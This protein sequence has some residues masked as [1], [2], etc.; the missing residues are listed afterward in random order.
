MGNHAKNQCNVYLSDHEAN[1]VD[2][3]A[4]DNPWLKTRGALTKLVLRHWLVVNAQNYHVAIEKAAK[5]I[6]Q[7]GRI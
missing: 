1:M 6:K 3:I 2:A 7:H 5:E 4:R